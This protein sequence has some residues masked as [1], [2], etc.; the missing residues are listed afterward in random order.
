MFR[1]MVCSHTGWAVG[2]PDFS[3]T[4]IDNQ[5]EKEGWMDGWMDALASDAE[6]LSVCGLLRKAEANR[7]TNSSKE[8]TTSPEGLEPLG[9]LAN[10]GDNL[11]ESSKLV[12]GI[13]V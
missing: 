11:A 7:Q 8:E 5:E 12:Q 2:C 13:V 4:D 6:V 1:L 3:T 10:T 9:S